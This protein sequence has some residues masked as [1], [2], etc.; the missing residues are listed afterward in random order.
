MPEPSSALTSTEITAIRNFVFTG[1]GLF[2]IADHAGADR[3]SDGI[4]AAGVFNALMGS[5]SIFGI[6]YNDNSSDK[7]FGWFDDHP[8]GNFTTDTTSPILF[9]G[10]FGNPS[11]SPGLGLFGSSSMT[12]S[13]AA[14]GHVWKTPST[15][16]TST[17]VTFATSTY[18]TRRLPAVGD[19]STAE[20]A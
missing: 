3:N 15:H 14:K 9:T 7:T 6:T 8:D 20:H 18:G 10:A 17:V 1:G 11:S 13:G 4:D 16:D 12:L 2:M 5:P 19:A